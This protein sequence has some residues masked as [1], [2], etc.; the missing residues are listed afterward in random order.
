MN[1]TKTDWTTKSDEYMAEMFEAM[2]ERLAYADAAERKEILA[3]M[4]EIAT[5]QDTR[6]G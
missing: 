1:A 5:E 2:R 6:R 3:D 4:L